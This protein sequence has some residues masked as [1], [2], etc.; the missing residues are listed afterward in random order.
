MNRLIFLLTVLFA[1][2]S[3]GYTQRKR[4]FL[5]GI[6]NYHTN[7]YK[8]W[9]N[10]HGAEDVTLLAPE[11]EKK[12]FKVQSLTNEQATCQGILHGLDCFI[13]DANKGDI[14]YLHFSCHGQPVEDGLLNDVKDE[15]DGWDEAL[16]PIDAGKQYDVQGYQGE[17]HIT[18]DT[19]NIYFRRLRKKIGATGMLYVAMDACHAGTISRKGVETVRGT[20][21]GLTKSG[22][23]FNPPDDHVRHYIMQKT[24]G[25]SPVLIFEACKAQERNSEIRIAGREFGALSYNI[26][27]ALKSLKVLGK[28]AC[29]F[30]DSVE[31][32]TKKPKQWPRN[33]SLVQESSL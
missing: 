4:G 26:C 25:L 15:K 27:D 31:A 22:T 2:S 9:N 20:K 8:V 28:N 16:V 3:I 12:G 18:D 17:K 5:I 7:G 24:K 33:Q 23:K 30:R 14:V 6:S 29:E 32:S 10:I 1:F 13:A 11:L 21:D 19:L